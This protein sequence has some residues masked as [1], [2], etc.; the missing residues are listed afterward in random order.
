[1]TTACNPWLDVKLNKDMLNTITEFYMDAWEK[2]KSQSHAIVQFVNTD[3][4][5]FFLNCSVEDVDGDDE[6]LTITIKIPPI[7]K[8]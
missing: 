7:Q 6:T 1:M 2:S 8:S 5:I 3:L 4:F